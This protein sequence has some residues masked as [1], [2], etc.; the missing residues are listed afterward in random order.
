MK[1]S[2]WTRIL[3]ACLV[4][5]MFVTTAAAAG[6]LTSSTELPKKAEQGYW[7]KQEDAAAEDGMALRAST[8]ALISGR[9][10]L[11]AEENLI[12]KYFPVTMYNYDAQ[13][14]NT[15]TM[16]KEDGDDLHEGFHFGSN[17]EYTRNVI[18]TAG[19][20]YIQNIRAEKNGADSWLQ[21]HEDNKI[22]GV[23][24]ANATVWTLVIENNRYYLTCEI[25]GVTNYM[26]VGIDGDTDGYT[27]EKIPITISAF[28]H[29]DFPN[30]E[31]GVRLS[32]NGFSLCQWGGD[33]VV[34]YGGYDVSG[35][36]GNGMRL[37]A[38]TDTPQA[39]PGSESVSAGNLTPGRYFIQNIRARNNNV[40]SWL[41]AHAENKIHG[42]N[43][44]NATVWTLE[45]EGTDKYLT[46]MINGEKHYMKVGTGGD[47][48]GYTTDKTPITISAFSHANFPNVT[49]GIR[50]S[51]GNYS[52]CQWGGNNVVDYGGYDQS[53]DAGNGML[54][55]PAVEAAVTPGT[56]PSQ[57]I[58]S[59][60]EEWNRWNKAKDAASGDLMYTGLV[61]P[62]LENDQIVFAV[63]EGGIFNQDATVKDIYEYVGLPF[64]LDPSTGIYS[65][66]SDVNGAYFRNGPASGTAEQP[67]NL[68][69]SENA[70]Q[71][72]P[73]VSDPGDRSTHA[74]LPYNNEWEMSGTKGAYTGGVD[75]FFGMRADLPFAMTPNGRVKSTDD[76]SDPIQFTFAGDDDVWVFIDGYLVIDL[77]GIHNRLG[78]SI[79]FAANTITYSE[80]NAYDGD[81]NTG[82]F[83]DPNFATTQYLFT[84]G[85]VQGV[86]PMSREAFAMATEHEIQLFYL[87]RGEGTSNCRIEF[88][89]PMVD[90]VLV[91]K[92]ATHSW[93]QRAETAK[94]HGPGLDDGVFELTAAEQA[95]INNMDF[96]FTLYKKTAEENAA[97]EPVANT[98][99]YLIG[100]GVEGTV[101]HQ[102]DANGHFYLKNGQSAKFITEIPAAGVTYYVVEDQVP[103]GF[104]SP[105]YN[106]AGTALGGYTYTGTDDNDGNGKVE[107]S[108]GTVGNASQIPEQI[109]PMPT[110][111][112][113]G[114][115]HW[116]E[117]KSYEVT[118]K[119]SIENS[120]SIEFI[121]SNYLNNELPNPSA[122]AH[123]DVIVLDYGLPVI[124]DPLANDLYRG[125]SVGIVYWGDESLTTTIENVTV[126]GE[127]SPTENDKIEAFLKG[128]PGAPKT[129]FDF[130]TVAFRN[131]V[132]SDDIVTRDTFAY[133][134]SKQL[135]GVEVITYIM[136]SASGSNGS[137]YSIGKIYIVPATVMYY[138]EN[139]SEMI[140]FEGAAW[141]GSSDITDSKA[142][143]ANQEP[144]VMG[145]TT[146]SIY[147]S[148]VAYLEDGGDSNGMSHYADTSS[149]AAR[150]TYT[151]TGTGT[152][153]FA[154]TSATTGYLQIKLYQGESATGDYQRIDYVD[155]FY[156]DQ[157][158]SD[159]DRGG[160]LYNVPVYTVDDLPYG[161]YTMVVT[162]AK[163][164]VPTEGNGK[165]TPENPDGG[166]GHEFFLDGIRVMQP[167]NQADALK[168]KA[169]SAYAAD[170]EA[171]IE[172]AT[173][174]NKLIDEYKPDENAE[175]EAAWPF[176]VMTDNNG[177]VIYASE[178]ISSGP[179]EEIYLMPGQSVSFVI[180][181]WHP[182]GY[183]MHLGMKAPFGSASVK[184]GQTTFDLKNASDC[185]YDITGMQSNVESKTLTENSSYYV[186]TYTITATDSI[187]AL[188]N[189]KITGNY[190]FVLIGNLP[191]ATS[192]VDS[193][194][195]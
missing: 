187:V 21:A 77:G 178:Y 131:G 176:A 3:A 140:T 152:T 166:S 59:G 22:H 69:F 55:F 31:N 173:L 112:E 121:C 58:G 105:D 154:R 185:Y 116:A 100:R 92:D 117:N 143:S 148:D 11:A 107:T 52:L 186:A 38:V 181:Y 125:D 41:Q 94:E 130:G 128:N 5:C 93:S 174:R 24:K 39:S 122:L 190:Q 84:E 182:D 180:R 110:T 133:T 123:E 32:Q 151:F 119:G 19:Q 90:T 71:P 48:D 99:F 35:D 161:T 26:K 172:V 118:V 159:L 95:A 126:A 179:K 192:Q 70:P 68:Y 165:P 64:V 57:V 34:H 9:T 14:I 36:A 33:N 56:G 53:G 15:A 10:T 169:L 73:T 85:N 145:T 188:T 8:Y 102:T 189:I 91:T 157:N 184:V 111:D 50:L 156:K 177:G 158:D 113:N 79:D 29:N 163:K 183:R 101:I 44:A 155:T 72:L 42:V 37:Y 63:P 144:G 80:K 65:F 170:G 106:F 104:V 160:V 54:F 87:E 191:A 150:F 23:A 62:E 136:Q 115:T 149:K 82:S 6:V 88:N 61:E 7:I 28:R 86:L 162:V 147:G 17:L 137:A 74:F 78:A 124:I 193:Q 109:I 89:L 96:G 194:G 146:D 40:A 134:L 83:N 139:F 1:R 60:Y 98:N 141:K 66:D 13:T 18:L 153:I 175:T 49:T 129:Q 46:C 142:V 168:D 120:D 114:V 2:Y 16:A 138:E 67:N 75:Y 20:Y 76:S 25:D 195:E 167:L 47:T 30:V 135:T 97:F 81:N 4:C 45:V 171:N 103:D 51:Q 108:T 132:V 12:V 43:Q 27:T 127:G 164:G